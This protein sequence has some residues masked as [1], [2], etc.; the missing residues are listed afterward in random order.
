MQSCRACCP[1]PRDSTGAR[2]LVSRIGLEL[3]RLHAD[4]L[5][6]QEAVGA[7]SADGAPKAR[8]LV[9]LQDLDRI[10]QTAENLAEASRLAAE[11]VCGSVDVARL[12]RAVTL[13]D[14]RARLLQHVDSDGGP[15]PERPEVGRLP[16]APE[17]RSRPSAQDDGDGVLWL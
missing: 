8:T 9:S 1:S 10:A 16:P 4:L 14:L 11:D 3:E 7:L 17:S 13:G 6:L 15:A 5:A 12:T 2:E